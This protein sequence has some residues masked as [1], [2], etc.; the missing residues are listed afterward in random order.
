MRKRQREGGPGAQSNDGKNRTQEERKEWRKRRWERTVFLPLA[1][2]LACS[3][4]PDPRSKTHTAFIVIPRGHCAPLPPILGSHRLQCNLG[5][6]GARSAGGSPVCS[7]VSLQPSG[8]FPSRRPQPGSSI[9]PHSPPYPPQPNPPHP[10]LLQ[11]GSRLPDA[12]PSLSEPSIKG[13]SLRET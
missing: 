10:Q 9:S 2:L 6:G 8:S 1:H 12:L 3:F 7:R 5:V 13:G 11:G 4:T